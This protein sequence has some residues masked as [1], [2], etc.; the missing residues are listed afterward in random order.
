[1]FELPVWQF[2]WDG[3]RLYWDGDGDGDGERLYWDGYYW[4]GERL[5]WDGDGDGFIVW[6]SDR[7]E[8]KRFIL[9]ET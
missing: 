3:E 5:Y 1:M 2:D 6:L 4:D 9:L 8:E 7:G